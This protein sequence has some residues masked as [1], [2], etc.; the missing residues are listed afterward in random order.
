MNPVA[1]REWRNALRSGKY[2]QGSA[3]GASREGE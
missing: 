3:V 2:K 1:V